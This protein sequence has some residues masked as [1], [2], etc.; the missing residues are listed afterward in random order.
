MELTQCDDNAPGDGLEVFDLTVNESYIMNADSTVTLHYYPSY[1]DAVNNTNEIL[2]PTAANVGANVWIRVSS[3]NFIDSF[4]ENCYVLVEQP[5][6]AV[7]YTHL[8][9]PTNREV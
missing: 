6:V 1:T 7:S 8:T 9:L 2:D 4:S 3:N 5:I